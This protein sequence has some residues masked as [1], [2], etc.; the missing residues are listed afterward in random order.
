M[1]EL[2][3]TDLRYRRT[4]TLWSCLPEGSREV[5]ITRAERMNVPRDWKRGEGATVL[6]MAGICGYRRAWMYSGL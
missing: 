5:Q 4:H 3:S 1:Y 2:E 6:A